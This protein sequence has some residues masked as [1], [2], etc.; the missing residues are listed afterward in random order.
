MTKTVVKK[1]PELVQLPSVPTILKISEIP[2]NTYVMKVNLPF[3]LTHLA[4][5]GIEKAFIIAQTS[6]SP[7]GVMGKE[8]EIIRESNRKVLEIIRNNYPLLGKHVYISFGVKLNY[9]KWKD[10]DYYYCANV[11]KLMEQL[12]ACGFSAL[13]LKAFMIPIQN[14]PVWVNFV[15]VKGIDGFTASQFGSTLY[16]DVKLDDLKTI[17]KNNQILQ[18]IKTFICQTAVATGKWMTCVVPDGRELNGGA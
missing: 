17:L 3:N 4:K 14:P 7:K 15:H 1:R 6:K 16:S 12:D 9:G 13:P 5:R 8:I 11:S 10:R 2:S 18:D